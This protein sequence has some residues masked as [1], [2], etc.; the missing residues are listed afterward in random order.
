[1][2]K[3]MFIFVLVFLFINFLSASEIYKYYEI[4]LNYN[5]GKITILD[6][7]IE[8]FQEEK[9]NLLGTYAIA[10]LD[11]KGNLIESYLF[12]VPNEI[13]YDEADENGT[14]VS[15]GLMVLNETNFTIYA[16]YYENAVEFIIYDENL[17]EKLVIDVG[18]YSKVGEISLDEEEDAEEG[19]TD[20]ESRDSPKELQDYW[21]IL[22]IILIILIFIFV[23]SLRK[24]KPKKTVQYR[25]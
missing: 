5:Q 14:I 11:N 15:G 23:I 6:T 25:R 20:K 22:L 16:P 2:K 8:F 13:L 24:K 12:N 1:M 3:I 7:N 10:I 17:T 4:D 21:W 9:E 19:V 18:M